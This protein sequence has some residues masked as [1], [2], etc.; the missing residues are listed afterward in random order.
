MP[1]DYQT[2]VR[3]TRLNRSY[4]TLPLTFR[5]CL[6]FFVPAR[7]KSLGQEMNRVLKREEERERERERDHS[8]FLYTEPG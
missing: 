7:S 5:F 8:T 6:F 4:T 3:L 2:V 1:A